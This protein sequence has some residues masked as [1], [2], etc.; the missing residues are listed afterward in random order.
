MECPRNLE[1]SEIILEFGK[2]E[3]SM[4]KCSSCPNI[5]YSGGIMT[6][7]LINQEDD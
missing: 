4:D 5:Q 6:C 1:K 7:P 3:S 2:D